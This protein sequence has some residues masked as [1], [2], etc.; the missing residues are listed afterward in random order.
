LQ[1]TLIDLQV[2]PLV[3]E[4]DQYISLDDILG[5][6]LC[7]TEILVSAKTENFIGHSKCWQNAVIFLTH[8]DNLHKKAQQSKSRQLSYINCS[9]CVFINKQTRWTMK[10]TSAVAPETKASS[11]IRLT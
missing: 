8:P 2:T 11:L 7:S 3:Q 5:R 4:I 9:R 6:Y 1:L 10:H